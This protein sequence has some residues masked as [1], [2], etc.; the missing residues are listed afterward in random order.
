MLCYDFSPYAE[1][2]FACGVASWLAGSLCMVHAYEFRIYGNVNNT[3][4]YT[5]KLTNK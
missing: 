1:Y 2:L 3:D 4:V 5:Y